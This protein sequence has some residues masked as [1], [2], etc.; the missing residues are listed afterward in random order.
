MC[1]AAIRFVGIGKVCFVADDLSDHSSKEARLASRGGVPYE[2]LGN[3]LWW[4]I[5]NVLFL[6]TS[7]AQKGRQAGN[8]RMNEERYPELVQLALDLAAH[9][10]LGKAARLGVS[11]PSSLASYSDRI[12]HTAE[13]ANLD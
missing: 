2:A 8:L 7:A 5:S 3:P 12:A 6:Y 1:A 11:L 9:D 13:P 4:T 10:K